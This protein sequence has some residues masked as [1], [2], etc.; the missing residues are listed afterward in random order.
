MA[1]TKIVK[2][3]KLQENYLRYMSNKYLDYFLDL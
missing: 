3:H 1:F 2:S